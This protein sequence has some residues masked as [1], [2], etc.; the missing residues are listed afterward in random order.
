MACLEAM[1]AHFHNGVMQMSS[2]VCQNVWSDASLKKGAEWGRLKRNE[3]KVS[4]I[5]LTWR[6]KN[7]EAYRGSITVRSMPCPLALRRENILRYVR[8]AMQEGASSSFEP[9]VW[10]RDA[11]EFFRFSRITWAA[12]P[13]SFVGVL[14]P[15][16]LSLSMSVERFIAIKWNRNLELSWFLVFFL[17]N[18]LQ[19][20]LYWEFWSTWQFMRHLMGYG[21]IG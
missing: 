15:S 13:P 3:T 21:L 10:P 2:N 17:P 20:L 18:F 12:V 1:Y 14:L 5:I 4:F 16:F 11:R 8:C 9:W 7:I 6:L 19:L